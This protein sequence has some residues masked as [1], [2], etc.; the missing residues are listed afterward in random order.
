MIG[1]LRLSP[2]AVF[3]ASATLASCVADRAPTTRSEL[4]RW[5]V[6]TP[7][8]TVVAIDSPNTKVLVRLPVR[9]DAGQLAYTLACRGGMEPYVL[10]SAQ[11]SDSLWTPGVFACRMNE[12]DKDDEN[13]I[14]ERDES[15]IWFTEGWVW[16][17][18]LSNPDRRRR[19]FRLRGFE[20]MLQFERVVVADG[21]PKRFDLHVT[22]HPDARITTPWMEGTDTRMC[23]NWNGPPEHAGSWAPCAEQ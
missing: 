7:I 15:A 12:G 10:E 2:I 18:D 19:V 13:T 5:P 16:Y 20:L 8:D 22:L 17:S 6:V 21:Q 9:D 1:L 4:S 14:L 23:R 3:A 11:R